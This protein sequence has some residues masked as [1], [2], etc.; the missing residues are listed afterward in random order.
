LRIPYRVRTSAANG[1]PEDI[2]RQLPSDSR[3]SSYRERFERPSAWFSNWSR[4]QSLP[5]EVYFLMVV[6]L[7]EWPLFVFC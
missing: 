1:M 6:T 2:S 4:R 7:P 5:S 3:H